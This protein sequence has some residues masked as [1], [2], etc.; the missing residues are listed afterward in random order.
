MPAARIKE[1]L[2]NEDGANWPRLEALEKAALLLNISPRSVKRAARILR[3]GDER[4]S[5]RRRQAA[6]L[7]PPEAIRFPILH[8]EPR[9]ERQK[10]EK[11]AALWR[12]FWRFIWGWRR[13]FWEGRR[14][15]GRWPLC[16][17]R[18]CGSG[19]WKTTERI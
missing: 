11:L 16:G 10:I 14:I 1:R 5:A 9:W 17:W 18:R 3:S 13:C 15:G 7:A 19:D 2:A 4:S 12:F 8:S 6:A